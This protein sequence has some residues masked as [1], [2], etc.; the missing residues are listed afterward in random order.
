MRMLDLGTGDGDLW[1]FAPTTFEWHAVDLS[2]VGTRRA[3]ARF[4]RLCGAVAIAESLPYPQEFFGAVIAADTMEHVFD[5]E[6]SLREVKRV[7]APGGIFALSVPAPNSLRQWAL[8]HFVRQLPSFPLMLRLARVV[9]QRRRLFGNA[10]FQPIDRDL[11][12]DHWCRRLEAQ[13]FHVFM[14][15]EWPANPLTP[16]VY[17]LGTQ[18]I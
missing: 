15:E 1:Q 13:G 7:L 17:L 2:Q 14:R 16:I 4:P 5:V 12:I 18:R 11:E 3:V 10:A 9:V 6:T 8:N